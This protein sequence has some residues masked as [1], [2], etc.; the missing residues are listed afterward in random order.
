MGKKILAN[1]QLTL[2]QR[3]EQMLRQV[4]GRDPDLTEI[5]LAEEFLLKQVAA[6]NIPA[7]ELTKN[8]ELW[9]DLAQALINSKEFLFVP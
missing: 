5:A 1:Q 3:I 9:S 7:G 6:L 8:V 4:W 2:Q